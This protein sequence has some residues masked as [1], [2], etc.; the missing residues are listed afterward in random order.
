MKRPRRGVDDP[1]ARSG[2]A[3][4]KPRTV[5]HAFVLEE[6]GSLDPRTKPMFGCEAVYVEERI[7]FVLRDKGDSD[8]GVWLAF[9][10]SRLEDVRAAFP[11]LR[12]IDVFGDGVRGWL[13]LSA[14]DPSFEDDVLDACA[15]VRSGSTL[16]GKVPK[17]RALKSSERR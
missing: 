4:R 16:L 17:K 11:R 2:A 13:K 6:L 7:V 5:P 10:P 8:D 1:L 12:R 15:R 14:S 3:A 9:D